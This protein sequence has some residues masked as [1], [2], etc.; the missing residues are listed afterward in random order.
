MLGVIE[1][2]VGEL[3]DLPVLSLPDADLATQVQDVFMLV[4]RLS[5]RL[6]SL[7]SE[8]DGRD[9]ACTLGATGTANW[10]AFGLGMSR[11][12]PAALVRLAR[13]LR[14]TP[15]IVGE[16][17]AAGDLNA[18]QASVIARTVAD[19]PSAVGA[20]GKAKAAAVLTKMAVEERTRPEVLTAH[21]SHI[22]ELVA[23]EI[24]EQ[25]LRK[26]LERAERSAYER[27]GLSL[28]PHGEEG[29]YRVR[30]VLDAEMAAV[31]NAAL[32]PL[33]AP[34]VLIRFASSDAAETG[35]AAEPLGQQG[36]PGEDSVLPGP[37]GSPKRLG[38][39]RT[40]AARRADALIEVCRRV[41][42]AGELPDN[43]GQKPQLVIT[44]S[45]EQL[46]D[47]VGAGLLDT[48]DLLTPN[49]VRRLACDAR[50][51][52]AILG[53]DGQVLDVGR[54]RRLIDGPLRRALVLRDR[55][56]AFPGCDRPPRWCDGHHIRGWA[57]GGP[58]SLDNSVLLCGHHHRFVH[59]GHWEVR[60]RPDG[61][62]EFLP[63][64][65]I[66]TNRKPLRNT[67]HRRC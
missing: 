34:G 11:Q 26:E 35:A 18:E 67:L 1:A 27:R 33:A 49:T 21:R 40:P 31:V 57:D 22:L 38:D 32:D 63:P 15:P 41:L 7:V 55:G 10:L 51:I 62:P 4:T 42:A 52:P 17:F 50:I 45:W 20:Q 39:A 13:Q 58:T 3:A 36:A 16:A 24:A 46:R 5:A 25:R 12:E 43:G 61:H 6:V 53:G 28:V 65:Y 29:E 56:C 66:D 19:L 44:M 30:G 37:D 9:L 48:G 14:A 54:A 47:Q 59:Q 8:V 2:G 23:P 64:H 60:M